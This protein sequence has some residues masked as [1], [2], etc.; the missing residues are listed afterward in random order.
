MGGQMASPPGSHP[1][2]AHERLFSNS[3][4]QVVSLT[5]DNLSFWISPY[6]E[7]AMISEAGCRLPYFDFLPV[8]QNR[9]LSK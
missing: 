2:C 9:M 3:Q 8:G 1:F 6:F 7:G 5:S 4:R